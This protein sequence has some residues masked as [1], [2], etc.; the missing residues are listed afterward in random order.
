MEAD[1]ARRAYAMLPYLPQMR[2]DIRELQNRLRK[3]A[4]RIEPASDD[5]KDK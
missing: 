5:S 4:A 2:Q 1:E 3:L